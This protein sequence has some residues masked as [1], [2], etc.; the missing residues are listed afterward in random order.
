MKNMAPPQMNTSTANSTNPVLPPSAHS[1]ASGGS[2]LGRLAG[3]SL[4]A[5]YWTT[6][7]LGV[8]VNWSFQNCGLLPPTSNEFRIM[9]FVTSV[10]SGIANLL[11]LGL[12]GV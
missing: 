5:Q 6:A 9:Y 8:W 10:K 11:S 2:T 4:T 1:G 3:A 7:Y 12:S